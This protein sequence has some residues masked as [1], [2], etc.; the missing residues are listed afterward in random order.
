MTISFARPPLS[1]VGAF[2]ELHVS[3]WKEAYRGFVPDKVLD[4]A[5]AEARLTI[6]Q[7]VLAKPGVIAIGA[8]EAGTPVGFIMAGPPVEPLFEE[9]DGHIP[10]FYVRAA[11]WRRGIGRALLARAAAKWRETGGRSLAL[12][13]LSANQPARAFYEAMGARFV[14]ADVYHWDGHALD[15]SIYVF[16]NL[17]ELARLA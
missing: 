2:A 8:Y 4:S 13:V 17:A 7:S 3:C 11:L 6:W 5:T 12:G 15:Q 9:M 16:E 1:E 14:R 10:A